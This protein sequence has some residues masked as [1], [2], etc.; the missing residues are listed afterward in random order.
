MKKAA[1]NIKSGLF[2]FGDWI[3]FSCK[4]KQGLGIM[5]FEIVIHL[6]WKKKLGLN[7]DSHEDDHK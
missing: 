1:E 3:F 6:F 5:F 2:S 7:I 4:T